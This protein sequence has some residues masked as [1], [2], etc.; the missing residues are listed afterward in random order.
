MMFLH[1]VRIICRNDSNS[2]FKSPYNNVQLAIMLTLLMLV[3]GSVHP[4][5]GP[6]SDTCLKLCHVNMR[7]L[8]PGDRSIK[9]DELHSTLCME[10]KF[11][12]ICITETWLDNNI[13][14]ESVSIPDYQI[15]R[16]DRNRHG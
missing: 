3:C 13:T 4:N 7:S 15:F 11:D 5:P 10:H 12:L 16:K 2:C 8:I 1:F 9:I 14:D 6:D